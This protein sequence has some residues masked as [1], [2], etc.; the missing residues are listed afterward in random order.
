MINPTKMTN[1]NLNNQQ[2]EEYI[3][4]CIAVAGKNALAT[5]KMLNILIRNLNTLSRIIFENRVFIIT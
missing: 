3:L 2:L 5:A 1:F 4:F